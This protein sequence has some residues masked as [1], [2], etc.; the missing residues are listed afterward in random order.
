MKLSVMIIN[1]LQRN[2]NN[3][4]HALKHPTLSL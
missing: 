1:T 3:L 2:K 4:K